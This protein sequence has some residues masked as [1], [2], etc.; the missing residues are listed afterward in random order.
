MRG[1][2]VS[3]DAPNCIPLLGPYSLFARQGRNILFPANITCARIL[4]VINSNRA[5]SSES[6][7][8]YCQSERILELSGMAW[9]RNDYSNVGSRQ[10]VWWETFRHV[11]ASLIKDPAKVLDTREKSRRP[12]KT[13][14]TRKWLVTTLA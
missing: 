12:A 1:I 8:H 11:H 2:T 10:S 14:T 3:L 13:E 4:L 6:K 7:N 5:K 9:R